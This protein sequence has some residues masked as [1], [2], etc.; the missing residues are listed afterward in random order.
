M[1]ASSSAADLPFLGL[2]DEADADL[3]WLRGRWSPPVGSNS[4]HICSG[5]EP[6]S[7]AMPLRTLFVQELYVA[8]I[9]CGCF[10]ST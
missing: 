6:K 7:Q 1:L 9:T 8:V 10:A 5:A 3:Y 2:G 4:K